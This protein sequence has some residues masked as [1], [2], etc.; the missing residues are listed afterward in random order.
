M[1]K[2]VGEDVA[3][4]ESDILIGA[5]IFKMLVDSGVPRGQAAQR[6]LNVVSDVTNAKANQL[7]PEEQKSQPKAK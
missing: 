4:A 5:K 3:L 7:S 1:P 2:E 6:T